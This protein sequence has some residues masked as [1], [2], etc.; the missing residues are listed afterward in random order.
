MQWTLRRAWFPDDVVVPLTTITG[1]F[2]A[3]TDVEQVRT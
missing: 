2:A 1:A 3:H